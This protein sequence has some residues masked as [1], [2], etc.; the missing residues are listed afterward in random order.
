MK[1]KTSNVV[2]RMEKNFDSSKLRRIVI[3]KLNKSVLK[4]TDFT[5]ELSSIFAYETYLRVKTKSEDY[6]ANSL[7]K[8]H[9]FKQRIW[10]NFS[11]K[12]ENSK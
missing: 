2:C 6:E 3:L 8:Y 11:A 10:T 5:G 12:I 7:K 4:K 9:V 1:S